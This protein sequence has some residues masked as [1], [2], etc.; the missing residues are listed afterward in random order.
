[1]DATLGRWVS[2]EG[3][4][5]HVDPTLIAVAVG[6]ALFGLF[7]VYSATQQS[8]R[9][10]GEDPGFYLKKQIAFLMLGVVVMAIVATFDYRLVKV[11]AG[12]TFGILLFALLLVLTPIGDETAG[13]QR[14][15]SLL[16]FQFQPA[17]IAKLAVVAMLSA[18]LS[19]L[20]EVRLE[21]VWRA[22]AIA[23]AP[24][25]LI[26]LQP[27]VGTMMVFAAV[28]IAVLVVAGARLRHILIL[29]GVAIFGAIIA[30]NLGIVK[31]YQIDRLR[32]FLDPAADPLVAGYNLQQAQIAIGSGGLFG[33]GYL[34]G[35]QTNLDFVPEQHTDFV[36]TVVG[37]ELG[38]V[39]A[40]L[41][42]GLFAV[43]LW[44]GFR[45]ALI[46]RDAFGTLLA[47]GIVTMLAFQVVVNV[48][49]TMGIMPVT[50]IPLPLVSYGGTSMLTNWA[51]VGL[52]LNVHMRRF[53]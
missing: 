36:F 25:A 20:R 46:S 31:D 23:A 29:I 28:L 1:M 9:T 17:E 39:G 19:E 16:G 35:T 41:L 13:A 50:G 26:F 51:A 48:G 11:Y 10:L 14:W 47:T 18:Y 32:S 27:D 45:I 24:M 49:M 4:L 44:R 42:L 12:I 37:E 53:K 52:L 15:I 2:R 8:L 40:T 38:F 33:R 7:M 5:R 6:L 34:N 30:F 21:H 3:P 43:L 22:A